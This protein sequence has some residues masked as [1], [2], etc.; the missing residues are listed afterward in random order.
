MVDEGS[1]GK[2]RFEIIVDI[3]LGIIESEL[4]VTLREKAGETVCE[5]VVSFVKRVSVVRR[6]RKL[7]RTILSLVERG[8]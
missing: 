4:G 5:T 3:M 7:E 1:V 8:L 6:V 2:R